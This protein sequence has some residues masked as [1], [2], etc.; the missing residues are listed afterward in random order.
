MPSCVNIIA[1]D[2][3]AASGKSTLGLS[4]SKELGYLFFDTGVMY[5][6]ITWLAIQRGF[7]LNDEITITELAENVD[8]D[9]RPASQ[10]DGRTSDILAEGQDLT[11][12]IRRP[13]V[14]ANV[15]LVSAYPGVRN[16]L[17]R[18]QRRIGLRGKVVMVGRDIGTVVL[19]EAPL[20][21]YL[22][23]SAEERAM[24]RYKEILGRGERANYDEILDKIRKRDEFDS[25]RDVAPLRAAKDAIIIQS[26]QVDAE[27]VLQQTMQLIEHKASNCQKSA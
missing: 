19:P 11:W 22:D 7:D 9:I 8:I 25:T 23:A 16:A 27:Q 20:K 21:I 24:R 3:P 10:A 1:I 4:L 18:Q 2:G 15:S 13:E 26:D 6:A 14:D 12:K 17:T 5:R